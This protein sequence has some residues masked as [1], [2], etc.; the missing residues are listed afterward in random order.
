MKNYSHIYFAGPLF[1][2]AE[3]EFNQKLT[4]KLE[5]ISFQVFL[6]QRDGVER[7]KAPF[8]KLSKTKRRLVLFKLDITKVSESDIFLFI[9][10]GRVPDEGACVELGIAWSLKTYQHQNKLIAGLRTGNP[11]AFYKTGLNPML[12]ACFDKLTSSENE[13]LAFLKES[14]PAHEQ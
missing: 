12:R 2:E 8:N 11:D 10:D 5:H 4:E 7:N 3:K 9:L 14:F 13:L 1:S 6:P